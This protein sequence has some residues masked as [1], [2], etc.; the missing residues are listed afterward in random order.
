MCIMCPKGLFG[1]PKRA[2]L[3]FFFTRARKYIEHNT[4]HFD[5]G[6]PKLGGIRGPPFR[7]LPPDRVSRG[8]GVRGVVPLVWPLRWGRVFPV[9]HPGLGGCIGWVY[10]GI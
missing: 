4:R 5:P 10:S 7:G 9:P 8:A 1:G 2:L 6:R 3:L